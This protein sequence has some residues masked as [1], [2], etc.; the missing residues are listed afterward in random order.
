MFTSQFFITRLVTGR[1]R[2]ASLLTGINA[3]LMPD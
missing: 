3:K 1:K 2:D